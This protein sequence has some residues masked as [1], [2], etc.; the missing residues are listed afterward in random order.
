MTNFLKA[1]KEYKKKEIKATTVR[2]EYLRRTLL[3]VIF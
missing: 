2:L 3:S 1:L